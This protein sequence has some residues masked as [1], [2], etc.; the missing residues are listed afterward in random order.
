TEARL[1]GDPLQGSAAPAHRWL[2]VE[3]RGPWAVKALDSTGLSGPVAAALHEAAV[4]T[5][6]RVLLVRR[7]GRQPR[8]AVQRWAVV[9]HDGTQQ[10]GTWRR[11]EDLLRAT[12]A[13]H[14]GPEAPSHARPPRPLVLVCT[15]GLHDTCCAVRGRPVA[16]ALAARWPEETWECTHVGGDRFAPNVLLLPDGACYGNLDVTAA[17]KV[18]AAHLRGTVTPSHF[19]GVST[20]PP[21]VQAAL[22]AVFARYRP[23]G[24]EDVRSATSARV[25]DA[26]WTVTLHGR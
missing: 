8:R 9:D 16:A 2:L 22:A 14:S 12:A 11:P 19:R 20:Q 24:L 4:A 1:R 7:P 17:E 15:H 5:R 3:H 18:V 26:T 13:M 6:G 25:D 21:V 23:C 10:W